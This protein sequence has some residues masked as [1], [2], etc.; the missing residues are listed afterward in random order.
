M[1]KYKKQAFTLVEL[2]VVITILAILGTIAFINLSGYSSGARDSKRVSDI[3]NIIKKIGIEEI[4]GEV[5]TNFISDQATNAVTI[6]SIA[7]NAIQGTPN[8][9]KLKED[10]NSFKD[11]ATSGNYV[12]SYAKGG[13]STGAYKFTQISTINE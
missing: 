13:T 10:G 8:F 7:T 2:I 11:P 4:K 5:V 6:N 3:N 9:T 1:Q 12:L